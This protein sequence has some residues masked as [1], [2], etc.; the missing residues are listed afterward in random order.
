MGGLISLL[1]IR[2]HGIGRIQGLINLEGN[3]CPEDCLFSR[4]VVEY[5][6]EA[7]SAVFDGMMKSFAVLLKVSRSDCIIAQNM[8]LNLDV[9]AYHAYSFATVA[10]S[11]S[12]LLLEEFLA[13][14][15]PR[16]FL[17]GEAN[18]GLSYLPRLRESSATVVEI[19]DSA[20]IF[21]D[22]PVATFLGAIGEFIRR[23]D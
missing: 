22:N 17:Y 10:E 18:G 4:R 11:D 1:Q 23:V 3:L 7:F 15:I 6:L 12:G 14:P 20:C 21:Y 5:E 19:P 9:R 8:D 2:R 13:L 16:L